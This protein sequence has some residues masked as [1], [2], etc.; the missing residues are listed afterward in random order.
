M[1]LNQAHE[2]A[3]EKHKAATLQA[4][5]AVEDFEKTKEKCLEIEGKKKSHYSY[6]EEKEAKLQ[7]LQIDLVKV[8]VDIEIEERKLAP[9]DHAMSESE[10][11][12]KHIQQQVKKPAIQTLC[13]LSYYYYLIH[14]D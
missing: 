14:I 10:L 3:K 2:L 13:A 1:L 4:N 5:K 9:L 6:I 7:G 8:N 12:A 11:N